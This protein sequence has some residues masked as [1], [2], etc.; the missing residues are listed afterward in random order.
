MHMYFAASTS[1][2]IR[3]GVDSC[4][5]TIVI[6]TIYMF[7]SRHVDSSHTCIS[8]FEVLANCTTNILNLVP[9]H[10]GFCRASRRFEDRATSTSTSRAF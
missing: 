7:D 2:F 3:Y 5:H 1:E 10:V 9:M 4:V 6:H 8:Y